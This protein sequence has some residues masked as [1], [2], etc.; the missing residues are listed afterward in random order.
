[1]DGA[2]T[3]LSGVMIWFVVAILLI[4]LFL[5]PVL[6]SQAEDAG[7]G[8]IVRQSFLLAIDNV[9]AATALLISVGSA[10]VIAVATGVG[11]LFGVPAAL[12]LLVSITFQR[13]LRQYG[14]EAGVSDD[15]GPRSWRELLRPWET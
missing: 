5:F 14:V 9:A 15:V 3:I 7:L 1:M 10:A 8:L 12:A 2:G 13:L 6:I 11:L 4:S